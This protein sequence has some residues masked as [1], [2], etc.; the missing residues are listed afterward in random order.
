MSTA[1]IVLSFDSN[2][3]KQGMDSILSIKKYC[4]GKN[5]KINVLALDLNN[6]EISWLLENGVTINTNYKILPGHPNQKKYNYSQ[7]CR[8]FL[9]ELFPGFDV[10][11]WVDADIRLL[12]SQGLEHYLN[13]PLENKESIAIV[14]ESESMYESVSNFRISRNYHSMKNERI[15]KVYGK[16]IEELLHY[17]YYYNN[18]IW[19]MHKDSRIWSKFRETMLY[20]LKQ[21]YFD[22][23]FDQ[24]AM[25]IAIL[26]SMIPVI[27]TPSTMNWLCAASL[28]LYDRINK[29]WVTP[30][31]PNHSVSVAH[32]IASNSYVDF[33]GTQIK[34]YEYYKKMGIA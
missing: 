16:E 25:N 10:Y 28:P 22:H 26:N 11:M 9:P 6:E 2:M 31:V 14:H 20:T 4:A 12:N 3:F 15:A 19:S 33:N 24:D 7:T 5:Y 34:W 18:G 21:D 17:F 30:Q 27:Y 13:R 1:G 8:A 29:R 23:I 32:L